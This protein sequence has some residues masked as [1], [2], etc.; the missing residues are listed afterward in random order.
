MR[1]RGDQRNEKPSSPKRWQEDQALHAK[2]TQEPCAPDVCRI[3]GVEV[4]VLDS[5]DKT[6]SSPLH[7][8]KHTHT[9][10]D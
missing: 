4:H 9:R 6:D 5:C 3:K 2:V 1:K 8:L 7:G 10:I